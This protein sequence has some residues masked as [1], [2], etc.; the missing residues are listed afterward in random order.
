MDS[1][2]QFGATLAVWIAYA[3]IMIAL[4]LVL[5][6]G[7]A[8]L[9]SIVTMGPLFIFVM[10]LTSVTAYATRAI[11]RGAGTAS[12]PQTGNALSDDTREALGKAKRNQAERLQNL[13]ERLDEDEIIELE[14]LLMS[15]GDEMPNFD[16]DRR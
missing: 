7:G 5:L 6:F 15:R 12:A 16:R 14:T 1:R 10:F 11:W 3:A 8:E 13:I 2:Y 4:F 9:T